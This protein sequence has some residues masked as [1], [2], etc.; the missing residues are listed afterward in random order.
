M[1]RSIATTKVLPR[2]PASAISKAS[3]QRETERRSNLRPN[4]A[5][6]TCTAR[7]KLF[8][9]G[10]ADTERRRWREPMP[11]RTPET[12]CDCCE[13]NL[14]M[15]FTINVEGPNGPVDRCKVMASK[16][17]KCKR[18]YGEYCR[19]TQSQCGLVQAGMKS[20]DSFALPCEAVIS[21]EKQSVACMMLKASTGYLFRILPGGVR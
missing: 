5:F 1:P 13:S 6:M 19:R 4:V 9:I 8:R 17:E 21:A 11:T 10:E 3:H 2:Y 14:K 16:K 12:A 7:I 15:W 18:C 20:L